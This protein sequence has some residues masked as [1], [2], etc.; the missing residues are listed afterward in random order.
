MRLARSIGLTAV[1]ATVVAGLSLTSADAASPRRAL[2]AP[3]VG[4]LV[5]KHGIGAAKALNPELTSTEIAELAKD[6]TARIARNG[7][8]F[9]VEPIRTMGALST[10]SSIPAPVSDIALEDYDNLNSRPGS[11]RTILLDFDGHVVPPGTYWDDPTPGSPIVSGD[12]P[13]FSLDGDEQ[14][15]DAEKQIIID[16]WAAVAEDYA[17]FDVNVTT[18]D[19]GDE[20]IDRQDGSDDVY[21]TRALITPGNSNWNS[22]VCQCGGI[23]YVDVFNVSVD[24]GY[25]HSLFQPAFAFVTG[26]VNGKFISDVVSHEVGHNL[27]LSH[28]GNFQDSNRDG[29]FLDAN[30]DGV[31]DVTGD[32][33]TEY[34]YGNNDGINWAPIMGAGYVNGVVQWSNGDYGT[35]SNP[36]T[37]KE[38]DLALIGASGA[39][40]ITDESNNSTGTALLVSSI[41]RDGIISRRT[42]V[43]WFKVVISNGR[44]GL[45]SYA[46]TVDTNLD[47]K[48][49]L[50]DSKG[51]TIFFTDQLSDMSEDGNGY[52]DWPVSGMGGV[53]NVDLP[54]GTYYIKLEG[55]GRTGAY[56]DYGSLGSYSIQARTPTVSSIPARGT[57]TISGTRRLGRTLTANYGTWTTGTSIAKQWLRDGVVITGATGKTYRLTSADV[58]K[59]ISVRLIGTKSG[60]RTAIKVSSQTARITR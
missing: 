10:T 1:F 28:D 60:Y 7:F 57:P 36:A 14:F 27:S 3:T 55:V 50:L 49:T 39:P 16:T 5:A 17:P 15:N 56:S 4:E 35:A 31:D 41:P 52:G 51:K 46:P 32:V 58:G 34:F 33:W 12:Y 8:V 44:L 9:Y 22:T 23:A 11:N 30:N 2:S 29:E 20:F 45:Y 53:M 26:N 19:A 47:T 54:N 25:A 13:A 6:P 48:L 59:K 18:F 42:D 21:G 37:K 40:L 24:V 38:D 43:D